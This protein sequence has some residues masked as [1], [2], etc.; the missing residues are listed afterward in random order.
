MLRW[1]RLEVSGGFL[2]LAAGL[3]YLDTAGVVPWALTAC[4]AH[5]LGHLLAIRLL[6]GRVTVLRVTCV[7]A[8]LRLS[9]RY[10]L[11]PKGLLVAAWAGPAV[12]LVLAALSARAAA[13]LGETAYL[14]AG[15]NLALGLF[16]LLPIAQLD[17][18]RALYALLTLLGV[19]EQ[20]ETVLK[21]VSLALAGGLAAA[22]CV[23]FLR[24][25]ANITLPLTALWLLGASPAGE[26]RAV[27]RK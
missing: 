12:N 27:V 21:A 1:R 9:A 23:L 6:G 2:L 15:L 17:G 25:E 5:E 11:G 13:G 3:Y 19:G 10:P 24:G 4:A 22:G 8:E 16:N 20:G 18:G 26:R 7:G 14:F